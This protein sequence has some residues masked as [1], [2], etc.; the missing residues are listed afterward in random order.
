[1]NTFVRVVT[2][3]PVSR[4][5]AYRYPRV[6]EYAWLIPIATTSLKITDE[7]PAMEHELM[8]YSGFPDY[9][10]SH[11]FVLSLLMERSKLEREQ[12]LETKGFRHLL[13]SRQRRKKR[14]SGRQ[15]A[16]AITTHGAVPTMTDCLS[17]YGVRRY[18]IA[19]TVRTNK[20]PAKKSDGL[21][22]SKSH[23]QT[24]YVDDIYEWTAECFLGLG[25][26]IIKRKPYGRL[27][28]SLR[29]F[30][31]VSEFSW[32]ENLI[33]NDGVT[34]IQSLLQSGE[35][36]PYVQDIYGN[37]LLKVRKNIPSPLSPRSQR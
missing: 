13:K 24:L 37:N 12:W 6:A 10:R 28:H 7:Q 26:Q 3:I 5:D 27:F 8:E 4:T 18:T 22:R 36:H 15:A 35:L 1:M 17:R 2:R 23:S 29:I 31:V 19:R 21:L 20:Y 11:E 30:P 9:S 14:G 33:A 25:V 34:E 16:E 32:E